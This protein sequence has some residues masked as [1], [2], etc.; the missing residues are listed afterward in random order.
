LYGFT[1]FIVTQVLMFVNNY[2]NFFNKKFAKKTIYKFVY[3]FDAI[4]Q[5]AR[6]GVNIFIFYFYAG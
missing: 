4:P 3:K 1:L 6:N 5:K 2:L